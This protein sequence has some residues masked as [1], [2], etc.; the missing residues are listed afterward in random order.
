MK[1]N[2]KNL[3]IVGALKLGLIAPPSNIVNEREWRQV[4][5]DD[6]SLQLARMPV[7]F[8]H[9]CA[10]GR[11]IFEADLALA[12]E[13][14]GDAD[15]IAY[16]CAAGSLALPAESLPQKME[17]MSHKPCVATAPAIV[18]ALRR[19]HVDRISIATPYAEALNAL[20]RSFFLACGFDVLAIDGLGLS[21]GGAH[22]FAR[23]AKLDRTTIEELAL[24]VDRPASE[25]MVLSCTDLPTQSFHADLERRLGKPVISSNQA[26]LWALLGRRPWALAAPDWGALFHFQPND[27][28]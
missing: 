17:A 1:N 2:P 8:D 15:Y 9:D 7:H 26:T 16:G 28:N 6:V 24:S 27:F 5:P 22:E 10:A 25:A 19:L 20:E 4:L 21:G 23:I 11:R 12:L 18:N 14:L 3:P 13:Q